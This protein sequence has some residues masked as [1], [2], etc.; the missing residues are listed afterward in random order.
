MADENNGTEKRL[1]EAETEIAVMRT[2]VDIL[3]RG[4]WIILTPTLAAIGAGILILIRM[5]GSI[6]HGSGGP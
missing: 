6:Q 2:R 5:V 4:A 3:W 1:R